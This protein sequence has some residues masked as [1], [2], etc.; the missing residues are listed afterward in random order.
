MVRIPTTQR[1]FEIF[2]AIFIAFFVFFAGLSI[3]YPADWQCKKN[4]VNT[5]SYK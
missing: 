4:N 2:S 3:F 5:M 1:K